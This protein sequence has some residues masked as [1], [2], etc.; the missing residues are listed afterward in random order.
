MKAWASS[1]E[2]KIGRCSYATGGEELLLY[3]GFTLVPYSY[4]SQFIPFI[5][6]WKGIP[7]DELILL[8]PLI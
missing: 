2:K 5:R 1:A 4:P 8:S 7:G 6:D 3:V